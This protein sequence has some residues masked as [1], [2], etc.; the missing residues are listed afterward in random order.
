MRATM[1]ADVK[2][3][4]TQTDVEWRVRQLSGP[5]LVMMLAIALFG[6]SWWVTRGPDGG[7]LVVVGSPKLLGAVIAIFLAVQLVANRILTRR[8]FFSNRART[9]IEV[10]ISA[11]RVPGA[12]ADALG[13]LPVQ[14]PSAGTYRVTVPTFLG[15]PGEIVDVHCARLPDGQTGVEIISRSAS[16]WT[17]MDMGRNLRNVQDFSERIQRGLSRLIAA[18][19]ASLT[20]ERA[21][22][23][24]TEAQLARLQA[25]SE[26]HFLYN[27]LAHVRALVDTD[28]ASAGKMVDALATYLRSAS[29]TLAGSTSTIAAEIELVRG[30]LEVMSIRLGSR[31]STEILVEPSLG[32]EPCLPGMIL[33][34]VENAA[35]HGIEPH[36]RGGLIRVQ[37]MSDAGTLR[38]EVTDSGAGFRQTA[39]T[40][41]GL[42]NLRA[43]MKAFYAGEAILTLEAREQGGVVA[44][45]IVPR[46]SE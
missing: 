32:A 5:L 18:D 22:H 12:V 21:S 26:S 31:L 11:A 29:S 41:T 36:A 7:E 20:V 3:Q 24:D 27:T 40:G 13:D 9:V 42:S 46:R 8:S 34:L 14:R 33:P 6:A 10:P 28:A 38:I 30:C 45:L 43:R 17:L 39:G 44:T 4:A 19:Q 1:T 23:R 25:Q 16:R 2:V 37:A 35:K 15:S